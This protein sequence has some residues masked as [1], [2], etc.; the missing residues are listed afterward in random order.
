M[1][2]IILHRFQLSGVSFKMVRWNFGEWRLVREFFGSFNRW[3][4][5]LNNYKLRHFIPAILLF[6]A[7]LSSTLEILP[8]P[9]NIFAS[10]RL[11]Y[12]ACGRYTCSPRITSIWVHGMPTSL[13][14]D[15][16]IIRNSLKCSFQWANY[17]NLSRILLRDIFRAQL[18]TGSRRSINVKFWI[19]LFATQLVELTVCVYVWHNCRT[20]RIKKIILCWIINILVLFFF[21][22][23]PLRESIDF[24]NAQCK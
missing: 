4:A 21:A 7:K 9:C 23:I 5:I 1:R 15:E 3:S 22:S 2:K 14:S 18:G 24:D 16:Q 17:A 8:H 13:H 12:D 10:K 20:L 11:E 19:M 6:G